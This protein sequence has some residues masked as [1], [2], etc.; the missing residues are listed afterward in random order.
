VLLPIHLRLAICDRG[1]PGKSLMTI[2][3]LITTPS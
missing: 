3:V 1:D 2:I